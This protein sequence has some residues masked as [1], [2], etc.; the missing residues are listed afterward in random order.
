MFKNNGHNEY[1][2][3]ELSKVLPSLLSLAW[4]SSSIK[5]PQPLRL[6][7]ASRPPHLSINV[8]LLLQQ[9]IPSLSPLSGLLRA[10][11]ANSRIGHTQCKPSIDIPFHRQW[12]VNPPKYDQGETYWYYGD[13]Y[14]R[15]M[16]VRKIQ[17]SPPHDIDIRAANGL[18]VIFEYTKA[19]VC[20]SLVPMLVPSRAS[21]E[22]L[23]TRSIIFFSF[24]FFRLTIGTAN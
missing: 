4:C 11:L 22:Q 18:I 3:D 9:T 10:P 21:L 1:T 16:L 2:G 14:P 23:A 15:G 6:A 19:D 24:L 17:K 20:R 7:T 8:Q 12:I 5:N 13:L